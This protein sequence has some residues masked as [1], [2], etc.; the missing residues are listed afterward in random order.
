MK[1]FWIKWEC[2]SESFWFSESVSEKKSLDRIN[3][4]TI[5]IIEIEEF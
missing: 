5:R 2:S 4:P 3:D 1:K